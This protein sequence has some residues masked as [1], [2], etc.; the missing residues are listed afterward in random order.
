MCPVSGFF[1]G[2]SATELTAGAAVAS[3]AIAAGTALAGRRGVTLPP[4]PV[5]PQAAVNTQA[6]AADQSSQR[7]QSIAG[8]MQS[9]VGGAGASQAGYMLSPG[10]SESHTLLGN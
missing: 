8:G 9:T 5:I 4:S 1:A 3:T 7:R 6:E 2:L 10:N